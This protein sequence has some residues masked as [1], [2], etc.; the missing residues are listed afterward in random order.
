MGWFNKLFGRKKFP[1][2]DYQIKEAFM[3]G[4]VRYYEMDDLINQPF[5][6]AVTC[7]TFYEEFNQRV[8][9]EYLLKYVDAMLKALQVVPGQALAISDA[10]VLTKNLKDRLNWIMDADLAYKLASVIYFDK[11]ENPV[12]YDPKYNQ[13]KIAF[14]KKEA[15]VKEFFFMLP[16]Q[17]LMPFLKD[18]EQNFETYLAVTEQLKG[19]HLTNISQALSRN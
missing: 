11:H 12:V 3:V 18:F 13:E 16:L 17:K 10:T 15:G 7:L 14:W 2:V 8:N 19:Q 5:E 6:R 4:G 1:G 9:R